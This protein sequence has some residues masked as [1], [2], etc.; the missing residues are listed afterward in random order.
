[1]S[2]VSHVNFVVLLGCLT[3]VSYFA[4]SQG[5]DVI[6]VLGVPKGPKVGHLMTKQVCASDMCLCYMCVHDC[7]L[8]VALVALDS[9]H[10]IRCREDILTW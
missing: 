8:C 9:V 2:G 3:V 1:M 10:L 5:N 7:G 4:G 6:G